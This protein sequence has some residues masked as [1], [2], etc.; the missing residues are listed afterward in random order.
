MAGE[1]RVNSA[2]Y[3]ETMTPRVQRA[4]S[5]AANSIAPMKLRKL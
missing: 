2:R 5:T 3:E 4:F 1:T